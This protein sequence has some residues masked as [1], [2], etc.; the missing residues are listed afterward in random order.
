MPKV[1]LINGT[2]SLVSR[3][4]AV[5]EYAKT[6][7]AGK[8]FEVDVINVAELPPEDLIHTKFESESIVKAN[9][10][11]AEADALIVV[12]P[13]YKASYTGV[14]KT[15]LDLIPQ[16]G[17]AGKIVLPL[18]M[19]GSLAHLLTID[20]ALKPVLSVLGARHILGGVYAV[21]SQVVRTD[22][23]T[24]EIAEE[25]KLRLDN[26]LGEFTEETE[27]KAARKK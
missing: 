22:Q 9:G 4:N 10:L 24:V 13:V 18:F 23:G 27:L 25:L 6:T 12:S 5:I 2:P 21:D 11:V 7:L 16:K 15:F 17:L 14:L 8:G 3:I 26:A 20:Y 1:V 19:G